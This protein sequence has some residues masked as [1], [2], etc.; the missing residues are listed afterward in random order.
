MVDTH[1][2]TLSTLS[3]ILPIEYPNLSLCIHQ[4]LEDV[5]KVHISADLH[6]DK[7]TR[8]DKNKI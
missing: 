2:H 8:G 6:Y 7:S 1:T 5:E 3:A 4:V